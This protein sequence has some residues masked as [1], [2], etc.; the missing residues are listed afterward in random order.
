MFLP[1]SGFT[2][3]LSIR[4]SATWNG[5]CRKSHGVGVG[6][7]GPSQAVKKDSEAPRKELR[8]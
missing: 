6:I 7:W 5:L 1:K 3:S 8:F 2:I 4:G